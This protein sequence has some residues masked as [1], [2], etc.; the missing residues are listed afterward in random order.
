MLEP[1]P[2]EGKFT[3]PPGA[4]PSF[5]ALSMEASGRLAPEEIRSV[6]RARF[7]E[8]RKCYEAGLRRDPN[9]AGRITVRFVIGRDGKV[10]AVAEG[11]LPNSP[12][13]RPRARPCRIARS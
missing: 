7:G 10:T 11:D 13:R 8:L 4:P 5:R 1:S 3:G 9:L 12:R 6:V 2:R